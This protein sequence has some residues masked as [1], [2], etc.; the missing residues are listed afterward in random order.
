MSET[1]T[2]SFLN[3]LKLFRIGFWQLH[4][5]SDSPDIMS[6][7]L[8]RDIEYFASTLQSFFADAAV[9]A[10]GR[11]CASARDRGGTDEDRQQAERSKSR[12]AAL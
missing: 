8:Y 10:V 9:E 4:G 6:V 5:R 11:V 3:D 12:D 7:Q 2:G 1:L